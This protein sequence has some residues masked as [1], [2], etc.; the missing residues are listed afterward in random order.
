LWNR[1]DLPD[2]TILEARSKNPITQE[3]MIKD[4]RISKP[5]KLI[6]G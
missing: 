2:T 5:I 3:G 6:I 1:H 4:L